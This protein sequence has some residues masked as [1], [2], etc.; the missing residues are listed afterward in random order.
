MNDNCYTLAYNVSMVFLE[1][2]IRI[3]T[4]ILLLGRVI[5]WM[6]GEY[7]SHKTKPKTEK[8][9]FRSISQRS[10]I[11]LLNIFLYI[12]LIGYDIFPY[13]NALSNVLLGFVLII[14][15]TIISVF[16]RHE[17]AS[18]WS[19]A[20]EYQ[21]KENHKLIKTGIYA[22]IRH[23]I[24]LGVICTF[25]GVQFIVGSYLLLLFMILLPLMS[26]YQAKKEE[27][28]LLMHF[29][30]EYEEYKKKTNYF[31]PFVL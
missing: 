3:L 21:I 9:S 6:I 11:G 14:I 16:A 15:A 29:G 31:L 17:L 20:A 30:K 18:N 28:I 19:H 22:Y 27:K 8:A 4:L 1:M 26:F 2:P 25:L 24:Y 5:Y 13:E 12:Q 10:F 7:R 23:P